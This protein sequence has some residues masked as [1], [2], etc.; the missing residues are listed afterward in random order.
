MT[1]HHE[2]LTSI[3]TCSHDGEHLRHRHREVGEGVPQAGEQDRPLGRGH[4]NRCGIGSPGVR[5]SW[6]LVR[7]T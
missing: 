2:D 4:L 6:L 3:I 1:L 7:C 5:V